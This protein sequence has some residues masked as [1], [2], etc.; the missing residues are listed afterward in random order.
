MTHQVLPMSLRTVG[1][2]GYGSVRVGVWKLGRTHWIRAQCKTLDAGDTV[3]DTITYHG[4]RWLDAARLR[5]RSRGPMIVSVISGTV[6]GAVT[7]GNNGRR[8]G[9]GDGQR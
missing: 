3:N 5:S 6:T 7:E 4:K 9:N 1:D 2:N 8:V